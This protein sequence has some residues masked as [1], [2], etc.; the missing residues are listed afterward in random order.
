MSTYD[1]ENIFAK[2]LSG[3]IPSVKIFE[4]ENCLA[5]MDVFPQAKG[6]A[7]IVPK[8]ISRNMLDADPQQLSLVI[9]DVQK[10]AIASKAAFKADGIRIAQFNEAS[11]GQT[12]PHLHFHIIP[13][14]E[15]VKLAPHAEGMADM[16]DINQQAAQ[17]RA[18]LV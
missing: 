1:K 7:L 4:N 3:D 6:H 16:D 5:I 2:I 18:Q 10:L 15:G 8:A 13:A 12:I 9:M 14:Y 17:I 11:A